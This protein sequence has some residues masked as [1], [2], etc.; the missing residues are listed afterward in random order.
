MQLTAITTIT[1]HIVQEAGLERWLCSSLSAVVIFRAPGGSVQGFPMVEVS[2]FVDSFSHC[3][4]LV[5][6]LLR[7]VQ[8][9]LPALVPVHLVLQATFG[10]VAV[11]RDAVRLQRFKVQPS[12]LGVCESYALVNPRVT[13]ST[14]SQVGTSEI[15]AMKYYTSC[16]SPRESN[17]L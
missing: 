13:A 11:E 8:Q 4:H 6:L 7:I 10:A 1:L 17:L 15:Q 3:C 9:A 2:F 16:S 14:C 5:Q 12:L